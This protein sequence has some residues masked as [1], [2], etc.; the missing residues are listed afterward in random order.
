MQNFNEYARSA[1]EKNG[2]DGGAPNGTGGLFET[3]S[4]LSREFDGKS[5]KDLLRAIYKEAEKNKR[6][7]TLTNAE[8]DNFVAVLSQVLDDK[9]RGYL[10]KIAEEL[11]KI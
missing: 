11:K 6:A 3:V 5:Q 1:G 4:R 10:K 7:G 9:K 2:K 8:I